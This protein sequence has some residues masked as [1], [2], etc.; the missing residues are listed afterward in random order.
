MYYCLHCT[1]WAGSGIIEN[2]KRHMK[3]KHPHIRLPD[4]ETD[5]LMIRTNQQIETFLS[6]AKNEASIYHTQ[7]LTRQIILEAL[8]QLIIICNLSFAI[9]KEPA[10]LAFCCCLNPKAIQFIPRSPTTIPQLLGSSL[11]Y[12]QLSVQQKLQ[13]T[14]SLIHLSIN[15]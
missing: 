9:I 12:Y 8:V 1:T 4:K 15:I 6:K 5:N 3:S 10:F 14:Q 13:E 2:A 11:S 7:H